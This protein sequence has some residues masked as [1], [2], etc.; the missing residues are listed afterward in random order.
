MSIK[1]QPCTNESDDRTVNKSLTALG[2]E[3]TAIIKDDTSII[4]PTFVLS[5][6]VSD[7]AACNYL[8]TTG[9][10]GRRYYV[11][12]I[13]TAGNGMTELDCHV[14]VLSTWAANLGD[15]EAVIERQEN[16]YNLFIDD[17]S[18]KVYS[19]PHVV[20]KEFPSGFDT[21]CYILG[22]VGGL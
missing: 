7:F 17:G 10:G 6:G 8:T 1:V 5:G 21:P 3:R 4:D 18:F 14:D 9:L 12:N 11:R 16:D 15:L 13:K 19:N 20:T 2:A 22:L